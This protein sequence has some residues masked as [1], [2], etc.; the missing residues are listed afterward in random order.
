MMTPNDD[1][2]STY[3]LAVF[4]FNIII[5]IGILT[6]PASAAKAAE[7]DGWILILISGIICLGLA[8]LMCYVGERNKDLGFVGTLKKLFGK[9]I[10]LLLS[11]P[12]ILY[13]IFFA[14]IEI[15]IF[16]ETAKL[17][18][19]PNTPLEFIILPLIFLTVYLARMGVEAIARFF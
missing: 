5:G 6:L 15:R 7:N 9:T 8:Y 17:Y 4:V 11:I 12:F 18:L 3:Q 14:S 1:K 10:G 13:L 16:A 19:L 2:I